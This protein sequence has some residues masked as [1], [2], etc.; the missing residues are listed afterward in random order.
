MGEMGMDLREQLGKQRKPKE[1]L[2][3]ILNSTIEGTKN[4]KE[5]Y[6]FVI[7]HGIGSTP[8]HRELN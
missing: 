6:L 2:Y 4:T 1:P 8:E 3:K 7:I 5:V